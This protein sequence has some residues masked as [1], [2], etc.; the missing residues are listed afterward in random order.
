MNRNIHFHKVQE[1][2][3]FFYPCCFSKFIVVG[4]CECLKSHMGSV[5][6][7]SVL[8][9]VF[10]FFSQSTHTHTH[11]FQ[12]VISDVCIRPMRS[13]LVVENLKTLF[14]VHIIHCLTV[15]YGSCCPIN[16]LSIL[17]NPEFIMVLILIYTFIHFL[18]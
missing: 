18:I 17:I 11:I 16:F 4:F 2:S 10:F 9:I 12:D 5:D 7:T 1:K 6:G 14:I 15:V 3:L 13:S 8:S